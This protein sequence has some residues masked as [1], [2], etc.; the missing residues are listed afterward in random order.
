MV[1]VK[2]IGDG[3]DVSVRWLG[4]P[5]AAEPELGGWQQTGIGTGGPGR[6]RDAACAVRSR[7]RP[8]RE[9]RASVGVPGGG[10]GGSADPGA[11][12]I[13]LNTPPPSHPVCLF[14]TC[15]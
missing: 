9:S 4:T 1:V 15:S 7:P 6:P 5:G 2:G 13:V 10:S 8:E 14:V 11:S 12:A 3:D